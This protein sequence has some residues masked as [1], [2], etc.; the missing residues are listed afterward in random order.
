MTSSRDLK[1]GHLYHSQVWIQ[2][3]PHPHTPGNLKVLHLFSEYYLTGTA[4]PCPRY[5]REGCRSVMFQRRVIK[6]LMINQFSGFLR[7]NQ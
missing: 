2:G 4:Q 5:I 7:P 3:L 1:F 6:G